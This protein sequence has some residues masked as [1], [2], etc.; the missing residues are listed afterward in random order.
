MRFKRRFRPRR[1]PLRRLFRRRNPKNKYSPR[2]FRRLIL[3]DTQSSTHYRSIRATAALRQSTAGGTNTNLHFDKQVALSVTPA[4]FFWL[5][6]GGA[7]S[8]DTGVALPGFGRNIVIRGGRISCQVSL[9]SDAIETVKVVIWLIYRTPCSDNAILSTSGDRSVLWDPQIEPD[10]TRYG[11]IVRR[12][13]AILE[14]KTGSCSFQVFHPLKPQKID[15]KNFENSGSI[16]EWVTGVQKVSVVGLPV[17]Q[18]DVVYSHS[19][20]FSGDEIS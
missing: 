5:A 20:S 19:L 12:W 6:A 16:L 15:Q 1:F 4:N 7:I 13:Q 3:N 9:R 8:P 2:R 14:P 17:A 18:V 10:F 11:R